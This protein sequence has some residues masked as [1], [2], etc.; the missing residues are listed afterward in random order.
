MRDP[1]T[2]NKVWKDGYVST[3]V[4]LLFLIH[5]K[6]CFFLGVHRACKHEWLVGPTVNGK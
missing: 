3:K 5:S 4:W 2:T 6:P 1:T